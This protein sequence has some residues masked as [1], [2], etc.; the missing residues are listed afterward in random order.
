M[1]GRGSEVYVMDSKLNAECDA[2]EYMACGKAY[3]VGIPY[4]TCKRLMGH[5]GRHHNFPTAEDREII[6][7]RSVK[8]YMSVMEIE[9]EVHE[10]CLGPDCDC[11]KAKVSG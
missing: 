9:V 1:S 10:G 2:G 11:W 5:R 8:W 7:V 6:R 4:V 3:N